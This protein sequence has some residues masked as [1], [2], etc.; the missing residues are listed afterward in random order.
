MH[1]LIS[2]IRAAYLT[3]HSPLNLFTRITFSIVTS[4]SAVIYGINSTL[5]CELTVSLIMI[6]R[7][8]RVQLHGISVCVHLSCICRSSSC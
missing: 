6:Y 1:F 4:R 7:V 8:L 5:K 2:S 3:H